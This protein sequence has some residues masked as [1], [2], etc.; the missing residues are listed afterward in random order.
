MYLIKSFD[1]FHEHVMFVAMSLRLGRY[2]V[3]CCE[4]RFASLHVH[5]YANKH[6]VCGPTGT[7]V[8][9]ANK[10]PKGAKLYVAKCNDFKR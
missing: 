5:L 3:K 6:C 9:G 4:T 8:Q 7:T 10:L 2:H 1:H